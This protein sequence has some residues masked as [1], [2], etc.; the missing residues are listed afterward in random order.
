MILNLK[1][2]GQII[3]LVMRWRIKNNS[4]YKNKFSDESEIVFLSYKTNH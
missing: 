2:S 4:V 3:E 1:T